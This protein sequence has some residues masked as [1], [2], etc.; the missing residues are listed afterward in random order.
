[1]MWYRMM[2]NCV[3]A[4][5]SCFPAGHGFF[6]LDFNWLCEWVQSAIIAYSEWFILNRWKTS[7]VR[8]NLMRECGWKHLIDLVFPLFFLLNAKETY[9]DF[10]ANV[11]AFQETQGML[12]VWGSH[13]MW[14]ICLCT[15]SCARGSIKEKL[16]G[17]PRFQK[18]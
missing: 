14:T 7:H 4:L 12:T 17:K 8:E 16:C 3:L 5:V 9:P 6:L 13:S 2:N 1:M 11:M 15:L 18:I 10:Y